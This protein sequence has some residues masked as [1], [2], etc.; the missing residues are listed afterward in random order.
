MK[1]GPCGS[2]KSFSSFPALLTSRSNSSAMQNYCLLNLFLV[3][4]VFAL[5]N[6]KIN[7]RKIAVDKKILLCY[8]I[9]I[10]KEKAKLNK[11]KSLT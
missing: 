6:K 1:N 3:T 7:N 8:N 5:F 4:S 11:I 10:V 9:Y 2:C